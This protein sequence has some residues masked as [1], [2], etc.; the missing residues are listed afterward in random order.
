[1]KRTIAAAA[2][3]TCLGLLASA[4]AEPTEAEKEAARILFTEGAE[5]RAAGKTAAALDRF[6]RAY[7]LAVTPI[8]ALELGRTHAMLGHLI[9]AR[10][11]YRSIESIEIKP[12]E[13]AKSAAARAEAKQLAQALDARIPTIVVTVVGDEPIES[14]TLDGR[15]LDVAT[16]SSPIA[17]DPG[18]HV[19]AVRAK[20]ERTVEVTL[21]EG[22]RDRAITIDLAPPKPVAV[23]APPEPSAPP[24]PKPVLPPDAPRDRSGWSALTWTSGVVSGVALAVGAGAGVLALSRAGDVRDGCSGG[25]CPPSRHDDLDATR[26]WATVSTVGFGVAAVSAVLFVVGVTSSSGAHGSHDAPK[27]EVARP[28]VLPYASLEGLGITGRF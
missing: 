11:L 10:R 2:L 28:T 7:D 6:R 3:A 4:A 13:S 14:A 27:K 23:V 22:D 19:I 15:A 1:M 16:L 12:S 5:L 8:T 24:A 17:V 25:V 20:T 18:K 9:E 26:T 21:A